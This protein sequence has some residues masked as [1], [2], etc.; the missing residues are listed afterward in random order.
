M[1]ASMICLATGC[2]LIA[3]ISAAGAKTP[4]AF[5]TD[6]IQGD[7]G[8]VMLGELAAQRGSSGGIK[9]FG[10]TLMDDH[11]KAKTEKTNVAQ[12]IGA[13]VPEGPTKDAQAEYNKLSKMSGPAFDRE[14]AAHM[15]T[16]HKKDIKDF[17]DEAKARHPETSDLAMMQLPTLRKH[18]EIA[19]TLQKDSGR[20]EH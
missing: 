20:R 9:D 3:G 12:K 17:E 16:D 13:K 4:K 14:F 6:G 15:T 2:L 11:S 7:N 8:E 5:I 1:K 10:K 18:L 19:E